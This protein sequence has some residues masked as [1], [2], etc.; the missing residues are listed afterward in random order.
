[1]QPPNEEEKEAARLAFH[2]WEDK[3]KQGRV[4]VVGVRAGKLLLKKIY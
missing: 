2:F 3:I 4:E 1:M